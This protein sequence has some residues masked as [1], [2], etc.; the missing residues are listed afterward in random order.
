MAH[1]SDFPK[2][3][4]FGVSS[5]AYQHWVTINEPSSLSIFAYTTGWLAPGRGPNVKASP[6][7]HCHH[8]HS[9]W[10]ESLQ[11]WDYDSDEDCQN[12][13]PG[14]EPYRVSHNLLL[15]HAF[16]VKLYKENFQSAFKRYWL[17]QE[18]QQGQ[19]GIVLMSSWVEPLNEDDDEDLKA[20]RRA[21]DFNLGWLNKGFMGPL[22]KGKYPDSMI[23]R[24]G[25]RLPRFAK[26]EIE[27]V[28]GSYDFIGINYYTG[29]YVT[30]RGM[31]RIW[32]E[33]QGPMFCFYPV[34]L[35]KLL[36]YVKTE[37]DNPI[38]YVTEN[39]YDELDTKLP[40]PERRLDNGRI[41]CHQKHL[42]YLS[43]AISEDKVNV[44]GYFAWSLL[45]N[46]EWGLGYTIRL[47]LVH[48][49]FQNGLTRYP[50]SSA[51]WFT[52]FLKGDRGPE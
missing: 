9:V 23:E 5:S 46:F 10:H 31:G 47:G 7:F 24:V 25:D 8:R 45:D 17:H 38:I 36:S 3:F 30:I 18:T 15:A 22:A 32:V 43:K 34:G 20:K 35:Q 29:E 52:K 48:V 42:Y 16:A 13:D 49:D 6:D 41:E 26:E 50:K 51:L 37:Y 14:V 19:I 21:L 4:V 28:K 40:M 33:W 12:G 1:R 44:K 2:Q 39:G 27:V 11:S